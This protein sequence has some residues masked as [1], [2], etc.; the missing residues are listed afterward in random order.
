MTN[1]LHKSE[2]FIK[3]LTDF[4]PGMVGYWTSDLRSIFANR[5]YL[6]WF[7]KSAE[8]MNGIRI[9]DLL[10][11]ELFLKNEPYIVAADR[12]SIHMYVNC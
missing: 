12:K 5:E 8:E 7:G 1:S 3:T 6:D 2:R 4:I 10:G 9:Q 11:R